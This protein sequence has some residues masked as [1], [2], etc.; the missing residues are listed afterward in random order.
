MND[1]ITPTSTGRLIRAETRSGGIA[2]FRGSRS[3]AARPWL[4]SRKPCQRVQPRE[5]VGRDQRELEE[6]QNRGRLGHDD[7]TG[8]LLA[9]EYQQDDQTEQNGR[10]Q[11]CVDSI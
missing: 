11:G 9:E 5:G 10:C 1:R 4:M 3:W 2:G 7:P 6:R 8:R